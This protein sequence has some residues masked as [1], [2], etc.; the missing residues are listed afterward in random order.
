MSTKADLR[1]ML[2]TDLGVIDAVSNVAPEVAS[3]A[4]LWIDG[5][6]GLLTEAGL[7]WWDADDIPAAVMIPLSRYVS[8][9]CCAAFGRAGKGFESREAPARRAL[10]ALKSSEERPVIKGEYY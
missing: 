6:R 4:D 2:L 3:L 10:A 1:R 7:C 5:S 9:Q 8:S